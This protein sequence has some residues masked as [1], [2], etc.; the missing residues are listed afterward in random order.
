[1]TCLEAVPGLGFGRFLVARFGLAARPE[2]WLTPPTNTPT[3]ANPLGHIRVKA[4]ASQTQVAKVSK[5][6]A[7]L[8]TPSERSDSP[9]LATV[10]S[11]GVVPV[12]GLIDLHSQGPKNP[13]VSSNSS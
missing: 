3:P 4:E 8:H 2:E 13:M 12:I 1:M 7:C 10:W 5:V 6:S 11:L 9:H